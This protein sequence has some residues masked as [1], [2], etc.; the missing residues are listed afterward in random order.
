MYVNENIPVDVAVKDL[1]DT[2]PDIEEVFDRQQFPLEFAGES[3]APM[4]SY[5][6]SLFR[7]AEQSLLYLVTETVATGRRN[8]LTEKTF[9]CLKHGHPFV[10]VGAPGSLNT[11]RQ[12]G[13]RVFDHAIDNSYDW[14]PDNTQRWNMA[15]DAIKQIQRYDVHDWFQ[16]VY[17]DVVHNQN[18]SASFATLEHHCKNGLKI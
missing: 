9:K 15:R 1:V 10:I 8:H 2:Y 17:K 6:L 5:Q 7:E 11:L 13:Y 3:G 16:S 12:L 18:G 14:E 4:H